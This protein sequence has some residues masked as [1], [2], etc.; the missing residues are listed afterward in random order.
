MGFFI[1]DHLVAG[2]VGS[3]HT[4]CEADI[5]K[6]EWRSFRT[7]KSRTGLDGKGDEQA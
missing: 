4:I 7:G 1:A 5:L 2:Y 3:H 6:L